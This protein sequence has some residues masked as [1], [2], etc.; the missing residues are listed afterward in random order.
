MSDCQSW[1]PCAICGG[2]GYLDDCDNFP[3]VHCN[4]SGC[5]HYDGEY[6]ENCQGFCP[7]ATEED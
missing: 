5:D 4:G 1:K 3:C 6:T 2:L 7:E